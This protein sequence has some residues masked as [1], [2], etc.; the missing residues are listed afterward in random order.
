MPGPTTEVRAG[1]SALRTVR[2]RVLDLDPLD[3][4]AIARVRL[5]DDL[6][7]ALLDRV[8]DRQ[9]LADQ[10]GG[11]LAEAVRAVEHVDV[12]TRHAARGLA[13]DLRQLVD[14]HPVQRDPA[15]GRGCL[16]LDAHPVRLG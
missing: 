11:D 8:E 10:P 12:R 4:G 1:Y 15:V 13:D 14:D 6:A 16:G 7:E 9:A 3:L 2:R 5:L